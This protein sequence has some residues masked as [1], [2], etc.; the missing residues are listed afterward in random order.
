MGVVNKRDSESILA[1][2]GMISD[3]L[4]HTFHMVSEATAG[5]DDDRYLTQDVLWELEI[6]QD[7]LKDMD[8]HQLSQLRARWLQLANLARRKMDAQS[9]DS[10]SNWVQEAVKG[11]AKLAHRYLSAH[12]HAGR[13]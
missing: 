8:R 12:E 7:K 9:R 6:M 4:C 5:I 13:L 2:A 10:F 11:S 3:V 1:Y